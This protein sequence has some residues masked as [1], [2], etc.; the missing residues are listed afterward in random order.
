M[1]SFNGATSAF[2]YKNAGIGAHGWN[3]RMGIGLDYYLTHNFSIGALMTG[4]ILYLKRSDHITIPG[5]ESDPILAK[6]QQ[7]YAN[8]GSSVGGAATLTAVI[9]LHF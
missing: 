5:A 7:V 4:D 2:D 3:A 9:G 1:G 6:A 8:D